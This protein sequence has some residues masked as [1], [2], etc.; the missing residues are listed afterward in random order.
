MV[1]LGKGSTAR[2]NIPSQ[3]MTPEIWIRLAGRV[4]ELLAKPEITGIVVTHGTNTLEETAYFLDL[5]VVGIKPVILG[6][7]DHYLVTL[8][9][10]LN[11][12]TADASSSKISKKVCSF[13]IRSKS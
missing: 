6:R 7:F 10:R 13:V 9:E 12:S 4:N 5:T 8:F 2:V 11:D 1:R 3:D